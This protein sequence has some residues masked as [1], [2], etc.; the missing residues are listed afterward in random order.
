M[1]VVLKLEK[2]SGIEVFENVNIRNMTTFRIGGNAKVF[3]KIFTK[4][5]L[6][7]FLKLSYE[8]GINYFILGGGSNILVKDGDIDE[9]IVVKLDGEFKEVEFEEVNG[10]FKVRSGAGF[11][12]PVL[13]KKALDN[14]LT[15]MEFCVA[16]PGSVGGAVIMNAGA[17]G[18]EIKDILRRVVVFSKTGE[19]IELKREDIKFSYRSSGLDGLIVGMA[20][21]E[22]KKGDRIAISEKMEENLRYRANTQPKGF[23]AGSVFKN[24][25]GAKAWKLIRDV[26]LAGYKIGD[27]MFSEKHANFIINLGNARAENVLKLMS[28]ARQR[29][30]ENFGIVLEPEVKLVGL[31]LEQ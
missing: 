3:V 7:N 8:E 4:K 13:S 21:F 16:I 6:K 15:G 20:E 2:V 12:L 5:A 10:K 26:G 17:H 9:F 22:L 27:A 14:S 18:Y 24:P 29:V 11:S 31:L 19:E 28:L 30:F 23:S 25:E 1:R